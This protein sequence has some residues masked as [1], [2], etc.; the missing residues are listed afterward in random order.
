MSRQIFTR[1]HSRNGKRLAMKEKHLP[2]RYQL[3]KN[4]EV[5]QVFNVEHVILRFIFVNFSSRRLNSK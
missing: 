1:F 4:P 2:D 3:V 5:H